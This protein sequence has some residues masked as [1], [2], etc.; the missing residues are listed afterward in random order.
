MQL[1]FS[2]AIPTREQGAGVIATLGILDSEQGS[3]IHQC[4]YRTPDRLQAPEQKMQFTGYAFLGERLYVCS[5]NEV[6]WFEEWPPV[7]PAGRLSIPGFNDLH[8]CLPWDGGLAVANTGLETVDLLSL[9]GELIQRW[10]L[11]DGVPGAR[12]IDPNLDYRLIADTKPHLVH[13]N[14]L[15]T[16]GG[17]LWVTQLRTSRAVSVTGAGEPIGFE[18]GMPHDGRPGIGRLAFT[19]TNGFVVIVDPSS[20]RVLASHDLNSMTPGRDMLGWCR[21]LCNDPR[22]PDRYFVGFSVPRDTRWKEYARWIR[23]G[24]PRPPSRICLYDI[25][26]GEL[27][28]TH[29]ILPDWDLLLFQL[30]ALPKA[31]WV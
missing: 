5:H 15:F 9:D 14:H 2:G 27:L 7:K 22:D 1:L 8:H 19:T 12:E 11:L 24:A 25:A 18:A 3:V 17:D 16:L 23:D 29:R 20:G 10:D 13:G 31:L 4:E 30:D 26:R 21:G 6:V 28:E